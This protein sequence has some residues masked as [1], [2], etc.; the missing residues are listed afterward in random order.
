MPHVSTGGDADS[1]D[2]RCYQRT[3]SSRN[4][5]QAQELAALTLEQH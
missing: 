4:E 3:L 2:A 1:L 5:H